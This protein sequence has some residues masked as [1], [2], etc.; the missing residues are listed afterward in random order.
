MRRVRAWRH[1]AFHRPTEIFKDLAPLFARQLWLDRN[2]THRW[3]A[4]TRQYD[5]VTGLGPANKFSQ[6]RLGV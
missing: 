2:K 3:I 4:V 1:L 5:F 6:L